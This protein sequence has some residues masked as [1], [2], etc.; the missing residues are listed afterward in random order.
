MAR[1]KGASNER[2]SVGM[3]ASVRERLGKIA[4][5]AGLS[6]SA[7]AAGLIETGIQ[8]IDIIGRG[9]QFTKKID[10]QEW[11]LFCSPSLRTRKK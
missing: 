10:D 8:F 7:A 4:E 9:W 5:E 2:L 11:V 3:S 1:P 6:N